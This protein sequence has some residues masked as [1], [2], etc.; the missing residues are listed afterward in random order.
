MVQTSYAIIAKISTTTLIKVQAYSSVNHDVTGRS[1]FSEVAQQPLN[2][3]A[4]NIIYNSSLTLGSSV[5][6]CCQT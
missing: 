6:L 3:S 2:A 1:V 5:Q 4:S